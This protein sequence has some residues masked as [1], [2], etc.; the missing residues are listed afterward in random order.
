MHTKVR[1][2]SSSLAPPRPATPGRSSEAVPLLASQPGGP[3]GLT[4]SG[5]EPPPSSVQS[6]ACAECCATAARG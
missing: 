4:A 2:L 6:W 3:P 1:R 5:A